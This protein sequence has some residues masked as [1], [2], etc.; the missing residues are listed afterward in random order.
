MREQRRKSQDKYYEW[1]GEG[2]SMGEE[3]RTSEDKYE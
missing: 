2:G 1:E 3:R